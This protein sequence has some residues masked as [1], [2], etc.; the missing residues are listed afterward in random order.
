[1]SKSFAEIK[2]SV[3]K[4]RMTIRPPVVIKLS[5]ETRE[6]FT[7]K[8][9]RGPVSVTFA[10]LCGLAATQVMWYYDVPKA[11]KIKTA[12]VLSTIILIM[13]MGTSEKLYIKSTFRVI[14]VMVGICIGIVFALIESTVQKYLG[15]QTL[16]SGTDN[17]WVILLFRVLVL[18]PSIFIV[19]ILMKLKPTF[20]YGLNVAAINIPA[21]MLAKT[22]WQSLG[23]FVGI[24]MAAFLC[25]FAL[26]IF[27]KFTTE[28]YQMDTNRVCIH[29]VL[30][31]FQLALTSD[32]ENGEKFSK[33]ADSVHK[34]ISAA[35]SAQ[36][37]Y[38]QWRRYTCR[39]V[40]HDFKALVK[41]TRPLFYKAYSLY[42][43]NVSAF[44]ADQYR[45]EHLFCDT[46]EKYE[47]LFRVYVDDLVRLIEEIK[48][49]LGLLYST[50]YM[51]QDEKDA[52]FDRII[53]DRLSHRMVPIQETIKQTYIVNRKTCFSTYGQRWN[54]LDYLRQVNMISLA[55]VEYVIALVKV[56]QRGESKERFMK[57]LDDLEISLD[58]LRKDNEKSA[59]SNKASVV[60][61]DGSA[62]PS[63]S[64]ETRESNLSIPTNATG[65][66][67]FMDNS[68]SI[69]ESQPL[70]PRGNTNFGL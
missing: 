12:A 38:V 69:N 26:V 8:Q 29:G 68:A 11:M 17:E 19:C 36:E 9:L 27:E 55:L 48:D 45:A 57:V 6:V 30:S 65:N 51:K 18:G 20:A 49:D 33:H 31:V 63:V 70:L 42:W 21:A 28:S 3:S 37:T 52:L 5:A 4:M 44:H 56:F 35:E 53:I 60:R 66:L 23:V 14:G 1:M 59:S 22:I 62:E 67:E 2:K 7:W 50:P 25:V 58:T 64:V 34:S 16:G 46:P 61:D 32:R 40:V 10:C 54:M 13:E 43:G 41:P 39:E 15:I 47:K 24:M